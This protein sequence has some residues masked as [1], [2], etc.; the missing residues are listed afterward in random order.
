[1]MIIVINKYS[2]EG[3]GRWG[4]VARGRRSLVL[5]VNLCFPALD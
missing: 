4:A 5:S 3:G 2:I 1:M